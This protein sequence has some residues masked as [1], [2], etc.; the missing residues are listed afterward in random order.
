MWYVGRI[1]DRIV[2]AGVDR[3]LLLI[4]GFLQEEKQEK[5]N[6]KEKIS[7]QQTCPRSTFVS[8]WKAHNIVLHIRSYGRLEN[9]FNIL[10]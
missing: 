5:K 3:V 6:E 1:G 10:H 8:T 9:G 4:L 2:S 7:K